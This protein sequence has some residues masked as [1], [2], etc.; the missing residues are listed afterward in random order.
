[1]SNYLE[2]I[3]NEQIIK[4]LHDT[5]INQNERNRRKLIVRSCRTYQLLIVSTLLYLSQN[6]IVINELLEEDKLFFQPERTV[7]NPHKKVLMDSLK[8]LI[9][10]D[11]IFKTPE[12]SQLSRV[13]LQNDFNIEHLQEVGVIIDQDFSILNDSLKICPMCIFAEGSDRIGSIVHYFTIVEYN[14][15]KYICSAYGSDY[16]TVP[17]KIIPVDTNEINEL[18]RNL[19]R[20]KDYPDLVERTRELFIKYFL[21]C[22]LPTPYDQDYIDEDKSL[23]FKNIN[24]SEGIEKEWEFISENQYK[25]KFAVLHRYVDILRNTFE[26][27]KSIHLPVQSHPDEITELPE[28]QYLLDNTPQPNIP[29]RRSDRLLQ[30]GRDIYGRSRRVRDY[31]R[32]RIDGIM[33]DRTVRRG[34]RNDRRGNAGGNKRNKRNKRK[35]N[36]KRHK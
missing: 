29:L 33:R 22:G 12:Q 30:Y 9:F 35:T 32:T 16:V 27:F 15:I 20:I 6:N 1:M 36:K 13:I 28:E 8:T 11:E 17:P 2:I 23:R 21:P 18:I 7:I 4:D 14:G 34:R 25:F 10:S 26:Q 24:F 31:L 19:P 5:F 3:G